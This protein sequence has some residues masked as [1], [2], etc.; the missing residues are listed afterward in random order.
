MK[1]IIVSN[2]Y[3]SQDKPYKGTFVRNILEGFKGKGGQVSLISL[4]ETGRSPVSKLISYLKFT[5]L[6]F[7]SGLKSSEGAVHYVHYTSHSSLGLI[8][9]SIFKSKRKLVVVSNVH[10]SDILPRDNG[11]FSK[12]KII[13]SKKILD[14]SALVVAPSNYFKDVLQEKYGVREE[15]VVVSP[16]G[17]VDAS[18]FHILPATQ[19]EYTFGYVGRLEEDKGIFELLEAFRCC[20]DSHPNLRLMI[21]GSGSCEVQLKKIAN[22]MKGVIF[23][24]GMSQSQLATVYNS[25]NYLVFPSKRAS[26]SLGLIPIEAMMCGVPVL[27]S[28]IGA[29]GDYIVGD[30]RKLSFEP[31]DVKGLEV[32]LNKASAITGEEYLL[33]SQLAISVAS[34]YSS[35]R[36]IDDLHRVFETSF[37][38][39]ESK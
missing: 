36:V 13:L 24:T 34:K 7:I 8:L 35:S 3:P 18:I 25:I 14:I 22:S 38:R 30:M 17:G 19:K 23:L 20:Q 27:S 29:T 2:L 6:S 4:R 33:L 31:G 37:N 1:I 9:A 12:C 39:K 32:A 21:A 5:W 15:K 10:G 11:I 26:E 16:S 28:T